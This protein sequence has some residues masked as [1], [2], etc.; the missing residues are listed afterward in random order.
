MSSLETTA[1]TTETPDDTATLEEYLQT[2]LD[3]NG[4]FYTKSR[5]IATE[6]PF[7]P[8]QI[9]QRIPYVNARENGIQLTKHSRTH[10]IIWYV[11]ETEAT[12][13]DAQD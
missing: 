12:T 8:Q 3:A 13:A 1:P 10:A 5:K 9:G 7:S 4:S 6:L 2:Q 11:T